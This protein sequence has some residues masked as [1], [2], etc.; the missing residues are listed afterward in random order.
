MAEQ[1][2][3]A[4]GWEVTLPSE[5]LPFFCIPFHPVG[6][7]HGW[8]EVIAVEVP[9]LTTWG[10]PCITTDASPHARGLPWLR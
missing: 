3:R 5:R 4:Q 10:R 1:N 6:R 8:T 9:S 2:H 7:A